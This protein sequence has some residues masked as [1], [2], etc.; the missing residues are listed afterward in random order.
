MS[1]SRIWQIRSVV[2]QSVGCR[3]EFYRRGDQVPINALAMFASAHATVG[4]RLRKI[5]RTLRA[6]G[7]GSG[8]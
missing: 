3:E 2:G 5:C 4:Q 8:E 6:L 7:E 1:Q